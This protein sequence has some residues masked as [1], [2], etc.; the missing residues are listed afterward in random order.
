MELSIENLVARIGD[1]TIPVLA[2]TIKELRQKCAQENTLVAD[3][4]EI[5]DRDPGVVV[6]LLRLGNSKTTG[7]LRSDITTVQQSLMMLGLGQVSALPEK[8]PALEKVLVEPAI[9]RLL[10]TFARAYHAAS[11]A[12]AWAKMRRDMNPEEVFTATQ[13][14][15]LGEMYVAIYYPE[16]LD[17]IDIMRNEKNIASEE[18]QFIVLGFTLDQLT[19]KLARLWNLPALLLD[20]LHP[21][22]A[23]FPRAYGIMLAVQMARGAAV[24]WYNEKT[25]DIQ[26]QAAKWLDK[27]LDLIIKETHKVAVNVAHESALYKV[28][29]AAFLLPLIQN[30]EEDISVTEK[31]TA[32]VCL[33]PQIH[34]VKKLSLDLTQ[35]ASLHKNAYELISTVLKGLHDGIALNRV[36][37]AQF[38]KDNNSLKAVKIIGVDNDPLFSRFE[39]ALSPVNLFSHVMKKTQAILINNNNREK[40]WELVPEKFQHLVRTNS[41][42]A[43]SIYVNDKPLGLIYADRHH[44]SCQVDE[45]SYKL[46]KNICNSTAK[47]LA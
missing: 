43:M 35:P 27:N 11:Q 38:D 34:I 17:Q 23:K 5:V 8:L 10:K 9:T 15:F 37:F 26:Q 25:R 4:Q 14:H 2:T 29:P 21:E 24:N 16:L 1:N 42:V 31:K 39:I 30:T 46:F 40:Y 7:S 18:A 13:L 6:Y 19:A 41:F 3:L 45:R 12:T 20:A 22:N 28:Q 33:M 44:S 32:N 47:A 36:V